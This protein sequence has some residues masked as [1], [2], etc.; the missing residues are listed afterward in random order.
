MLDVLTLPLSLQEEHGINPLRWG[1][2]Y[3]LE[4]PTQDIYLAVPWCHNCQ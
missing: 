4:L 3:A 2:E 1:L